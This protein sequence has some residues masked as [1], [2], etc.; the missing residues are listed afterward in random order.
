MSSNMK[1]GLLAALVLTTCGAAS[2][3]MAAGRDDDLS[4]SAAQVEREWLQQHPLFQNHMGN[5]GAAYDYIGTPD[6]PRS[7]RSR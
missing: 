4:A 7:R 2:A 1:N 6:R 3:A 5:G